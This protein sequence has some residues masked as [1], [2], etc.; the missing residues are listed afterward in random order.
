[1]L[2]VQVVLVLAVEKVNLQ[3]WTHNRLQACIR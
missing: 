3:V 1:M 2:S